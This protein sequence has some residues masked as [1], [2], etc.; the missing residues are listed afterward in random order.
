MSL[1]REAAHRDLVL[2]V[3]GIRPSTVEAIETYRN[4][5]NKSISILIL[6]DQKKKKLLKEAQIYG[7]NK[8]VTVISCDTDIPVQIKK[9]LAPYKER[10][11]A[12][13]SQFENSIPTLTPFAAHRKASFWQMN[14]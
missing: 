10:L 5:Y 2:F 9:T 8:K 14:F 11:L 13:T 6:V 3:N 12:A 4:R 7:T 1:F